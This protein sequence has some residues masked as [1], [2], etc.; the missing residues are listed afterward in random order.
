MDL[1][2]YKIL[3]S[4]TYAMLISKNDHYKVT[5]HLSWHWILIKSTHAST[6]IIKSRKYIDKFMLCKNTNDDI[7]EIKNNSNN[8]HNDDDENIDYWIEVLQLTKE[9]NVPHPNIWLNI[10]HF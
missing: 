4:K 8:A 5:I 9:E 6:I 3:I 2:F 1:I 7:I 10:Q